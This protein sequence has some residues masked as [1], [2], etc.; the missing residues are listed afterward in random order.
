[1]AWAAVQEAM[2]TGRL[3]PGCTPLGGRAWAAGREEARGA[4]REAGGGGCSGGG[5]GGSS[6]VGGAAARPA[7]VVVERRWRWN[8]EPG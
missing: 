5:S 2:Q 8:P 6:G 4:G 7:A 3:L 1:M